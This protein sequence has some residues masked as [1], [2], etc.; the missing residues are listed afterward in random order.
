VHWLCR[1]G[2][3]RW[4]TFATSRDRGETIDVYHWTVCERSEDCGYGVP[5]LKDVMTIQKVRN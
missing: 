5:I 4:T 1:L 2:I 3:H